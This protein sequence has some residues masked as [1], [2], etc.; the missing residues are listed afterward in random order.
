[1]KI[2]NLGCGTKMGS[3]PEVVNV[4]WSLMLRIRRI[5]LLR[6]LASTRLTGKRLA[7]L[8][9]LPDKVEVYDH[10]RGM[11]YTI[12]LFGVAYYSHLFEHRERDIVPGFLTA[13]HRALKP[14]GLY[15]VVGPDYELACRSYRESVERSM[16]DPAAARG[17]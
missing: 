5:P 4:D 8:R 12:G 11:P 14:D 7:R 9:S 13:V 2:R 16:A 3:R 10:S 6:S 17:R 15:R 1:M